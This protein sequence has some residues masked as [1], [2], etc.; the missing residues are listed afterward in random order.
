[1]LTDPAGQ[2]LEVP[3]IRVGQRCKGSSALQVCRAATPRVYNLNGAA[4]EKTSKNKIRHYYHGGRV[5]RIACSARLLQLQ[6]VQNQSLFW[7]HSFGSEVQ[8]RARPRHGLGL[9]R[10][11]GHRARVCRP[12]VS[13]SSQSNVILVLCRSLSPF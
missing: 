10:G 9:G 8:F 1:V 5:M 7:Y 6:T 2:G 11:S 13:S 4:G 12:S 3:G